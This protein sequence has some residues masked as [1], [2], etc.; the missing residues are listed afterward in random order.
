MLPITDAR[1]HFRLYWLNMN[2]RPSNNSQTFYCSLNHFL[3]DLG[4]HKKRKT[5]SSPT[6]VEGGFHIDGEDVG[7]GGRL[8]PR[9]DVV[10]GDDVVLHL[11]IL[12][13]INTLINYNDEND[14]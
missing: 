3:H 7:T 6:E 9:V 11:H 12:K 2:V 4:N 13:P 10:H 14:R 1:T 8:D 5:V